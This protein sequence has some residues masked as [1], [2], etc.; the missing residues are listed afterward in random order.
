MFSK[1]GLRM[2]L[3]EYFAAEEIF[4]PYAEDLKE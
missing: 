3:M 4:V 1:D 2:E